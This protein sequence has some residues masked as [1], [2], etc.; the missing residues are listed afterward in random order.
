MK[1]ALEARL[2]DSNLDVNQSSTQRQ[3]EISVVAVNETEKK[4]LPLNLCLI[5]DH[6]GSMQGR[7]ISTVKQAAIA[8]IEK[9]NKDDYI[10]VVAFNHKAKI[11]IPNQKVTNLDNI[12]KEI[13]ALKADGGTAIDEGLKL[14]IQE[15]ATNKKN[16]VSQILLLTDGENEHGD[17]N[18]CLDLAKLAAEYNITLNSLGFGQ[19]WNQDVLEKIADSANGSL[20]H[21]E[22]PEKAVDEFNRLLVR[23]KSVGLTNAYLILELNNNVQLAKLKPIAQVY[24]ETIE[25]PVSEQD[26]KIAVRLGD[27]MIQERLI[28]VNLYVGKLSLGLQNIVRV[29]VRYDDPNLNVNGLY[30]ETIPVNVNVQSMYQA[31]RN[32]QVQKSVLRLAKYRQTQIAEEKLQRGDVLGAATMLQTAAR[33]AVQLG[34]KKAATVLQFSATRLQTGENLSEMDK[35]KTRMAAKTRLQPPE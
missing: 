27:L 14:G 29:Q 25:L 30:S 1:V 7:P 3:L 19:N 21:I 16:R 10:S 31:K 32:P 23:I 6:S 8:L 34:D 15:V 11:I 35:K 28:L 9:L 13:N 4:R 5:L 18:L 22:T 33:T 20:S 24:P 12:K 2:N 17:N 26:N